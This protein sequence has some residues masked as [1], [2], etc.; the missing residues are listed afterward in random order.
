MRRRLFALAGFASGALAGTAAYRR[1]FGGGRERRAC[2]DGCLRAWVRREPRAARRLLRRRLLRD[3]RTGLAGGGQ[4]AAAGP[5]GPGG[6]ATGMKEAELREALVSAAYLE[7][8]FV[9]RS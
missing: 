1:W 6:W 4:A 7:G 5:P 3:V 8:D 9:L 2:G